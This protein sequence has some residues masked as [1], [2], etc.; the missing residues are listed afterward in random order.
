MFNLKKIATFVLSALFFMS[1]I[2]YAENNSKTPT[3]VVI[4]KTVG[5]P[6]WTEVGY[7]VVDAGKQLNVKAVYNG[8][9]TAS[10]ADQI[11]IMEGCIARKVDGIGVSPND[12]GALKSVINRAIKNGIPVVTLDS[13][14]PESERVSFIGTNNILA[15]RILGEKLVEIIGPKGEVVLLTGGLGAR[16]LNERIQGFK[17]VISKYPDIKIIGMQANND[18]STLALSQAESILQANP[19]LKAFVGINQPSAP[20]AARAVKA[21]NKKGKVLVVGFDATPD[22]RQFIRDGYIQG[23]VVQKQYWMGFISVK[24]LN[25]IYTNKK[26][27]I[28]E[29]IKIVNENIDTG[30]DFV[31]PQNIEKYFPKNDGK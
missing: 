19:N 16:N 2:L 15:G 29:T 17:E 10:S 20:A 28:P 3:F 26:L 31:T 24:V 30:I 1:G 8:P 5:L 14:S 25:D 21:A 11:S 27:G 22:I 6:Y 9:S 4:P 13:D 12:P 18:D 7:G 23:T